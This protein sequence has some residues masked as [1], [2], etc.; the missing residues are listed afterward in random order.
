MYVYSM[1]SSARKPQSPTIAMTD[2]DDV[3]NDKQLVVEYCQYQ[4]HPV[5]LVVDRRDGA[6]AL[7]VKA[8]SDNISLAYGDETLKF[9]A[10]EVMKFAAAQN[11][12]KLGDSGMTLNFIG[13]YPMWGPYKYH[14]GMRSTY[15]CLYFANCTSV[16]G[17]VI[18]TQGQ[19]SRPPY[20]R[21]DKID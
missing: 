14:N 13:R 3:S 21:Y 8:E 1:H 12:A 5:Q 17:S 18:E 2:N 16:H 7:R 11:G 19:P 4:G 15:D 10:D 20:D 9:L 6:V